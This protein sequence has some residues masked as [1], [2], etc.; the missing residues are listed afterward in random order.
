MAR[1]LA[2]RPFASTERLSE[3]FPRSF[4]SVKSTSPKP[5]TVI[6]S[7]WPRTLSLEAVK[8]EPA[9]R[10][11]IVR[12]V[13]S[14]ASM[15]PVKAAG[16]VAVPSRTLTV[17]VVASGM[18]ILPLKV[19][20]VSVFLSPTLKVISV[21]SAIVIFLAFAPSAFTTNSDAETYSANVT[22]PPAFRTVNV[23]RPSIFSP[24][25]ARFFVL[26]ATVKVSTLFM[27]S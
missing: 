4:A 20:L 7:T 14:G 19:S 13:T 16:P 17:N 25:N 15:F 2:Y 1:K 6:F 22:S 5:V 27:A 23:S 11:L 8:D 9:E 21:M 24:D 18:I 12:S 10:V 3:S 26:F